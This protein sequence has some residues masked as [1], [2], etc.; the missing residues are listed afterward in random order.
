MAV[1]FHI[2]I[3]QISDDATDAL[4]FAAYHGQLSKRSDTNSI[5]DN[6]L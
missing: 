2:D 4:V 3:S 1:M 6:Q 5:K